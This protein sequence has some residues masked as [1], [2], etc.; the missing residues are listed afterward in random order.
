METCR[1]IQR[2]TT[3]KSHKHASTENEKQKTR[4]IQ[5]GEGCGFNI[6]HTDLLRQPDTCKQRN[7]K[8]CSYADMTLL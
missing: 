4:Q 7:E 8:N 5:T 1:S 2:T 3:E 6:N